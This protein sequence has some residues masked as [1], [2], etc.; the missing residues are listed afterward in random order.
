MIN[1]SPSASLGNVCLVLSWEGG[2]VVDPSCYKPDLWNLGSLR[3]HFSF[4]FKNLVDTENP[5]SGRCFLKCQEK[6]AISRLGV[7][8]HVTLWS[9]S[10]RSHRPGS[11][12]RLECLLSPAEPLSGRTLGRPSLPRNEL[13]RAG[14]L[15]G[16][17]DAGGHG[18]TR[19]HSD[20]G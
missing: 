2:F 6:G 7:C 10:P 13:Q 5:S 14:A 16:S 8:C 20:T 12:F 17:G 1:T 11:C 15:G 3:P 18:D 4:H 19:I 9:G